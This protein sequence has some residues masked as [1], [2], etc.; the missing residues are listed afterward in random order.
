[1]LAIELHLILFIN[2][3]Q[4]QLA[5]VT[6]LDISHDPRAVGLPRPRGRCSYG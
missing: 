3:S 5:N 6:A 4:G 2:Q 1:M